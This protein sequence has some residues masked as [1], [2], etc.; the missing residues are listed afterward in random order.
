MA[1]ERRLFFAPSRWVGF[2]A[3]SQVLV[4]CFFGLR[5]LRAELT[6]HVLALKVLLDRRDVVVQKLFVEVL[7]VSRASFRLTFRRAVLVA[8]NLGWVGACLD[9]WEGH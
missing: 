3:I 4:T 2:L 8:F 5:P 7:V 9:S 1:R 6:G